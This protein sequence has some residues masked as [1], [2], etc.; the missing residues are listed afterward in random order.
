[1]EYTFKKE[2]LTLQSTDGKNSLSVK[3]YLPGD[4]EVKAVLQISHGMT[5]YVERYEELASYLSREGIALVGNDHLGHGDTVASP[6]DF[7]FFASEGGVNFLVDD[8]HSVT[9]YITERFGMRPVLMGHS[10]GSFIARLYAVKYPED[11]GG[12]IIHG[13]AGKNPAL[14]FGRAIVSLLKLLRGER[15]RSGFVRSLADGGYNRA[16]DK[17]EGEGAWLTRDPE[18]VADRIGNP[19]NDFTFTLS[20]YG[21]LFA[22]LTECNSAGW[23][24]NY[25]VTLPTLIMSGDRDPVGGFGKGVRE[26]FSGLTE[27]GASVSLKLYP[28]ARHEL[29]NEIAETRLQSFADIAA[30]VLGKENAE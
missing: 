26:V 21:D 29:F 18:M 5:D 30:F 22:M 1:M 13:T 11:I 28:E 20:G 12:I 6:L 7:G 3:C 2:I 8:L 10:M 27:V 25:P 14:P 16:F 23:Y 24:K 15:H 19:K 9:E 4:G 17:S